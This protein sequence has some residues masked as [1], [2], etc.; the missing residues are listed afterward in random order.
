MITY[1]LVKYLADDG[2]ICMGFLPAIF[3]DICIAAIVCE[4]LTN[5]FKRK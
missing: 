4:M 5:I 3:A 2:F 1:L